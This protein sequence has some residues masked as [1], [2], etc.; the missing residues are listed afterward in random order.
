MTE[1]REGLRARHDT[2]KAYGQKGKQRDDIVSPSF[3]NKQEQGDGQN[4]DD[5]YLLC[6]HLDTADSPIGQSRPHGGFWLYAEEIY[7]MCTVNPS[8]IVGLNLTTTQRAS[9]V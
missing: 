6:C 7:T 3:S 2:S 1:S 5:E 8:F 4:C 9:A